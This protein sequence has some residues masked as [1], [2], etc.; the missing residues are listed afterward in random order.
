MKF[1][2]REIDSLDHRIAL[3]FVTGTSAALSAA[4]VPV[5]FQSDRTSINTNLT[6]SRFREILQYDVL[7]DIE[8]GPW[9]HNNVAMDS[10]LKYL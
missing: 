1:R 7:A 10:G 8:T 2:S 9:L 4:D 6:A 3:K 5:K